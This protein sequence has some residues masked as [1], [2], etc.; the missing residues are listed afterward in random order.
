VG[1]STQVEILAEYLTARGYSVRKVWLRGPHTLAFL[2]SNILIKMGRRRQI[3]NPF[4]RMKTL[5]NI[6]SNPIIKKLWALIE[7]VSVLPLLLLKVLLPLKM[8]Y[9]IVADRYVLDVVVST[10][11]YVNDLS[12]I[13]Q[14]TAEV[15]L[16]FI[17]SNSVLIHLDADYDTLVTRR[18]RLVE[19]RSFIDFQKEGYASLSERVST[20]YIDTSNLT[21]DETSGAIQ[22]ILE[23]TGGWK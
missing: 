8:G 7:F 22:R 12:F 18:G 13:R 14:R 16:K 20:H 19:P 23:T 15:L 1:K 17:P 2:L 6:G 4:G 5:P 11:F 21:V 10:A 3:A 9:F